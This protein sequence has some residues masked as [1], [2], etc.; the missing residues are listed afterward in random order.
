MD[1][2]HFFLVGLCM[3]SAQV[4]VSDFFSDAASFESF[5]TDP[6]Q[7]FV[8][9]GGTTLV[10]LGN[11]KSV[12]PLPTKLGY[13]KFLRWT[14]HVDPATHC[15]FFAHA[16]ENKVVW[17]LEPGQRVFAWPNI[18]GTLVGEELPLPPK[19]APPT[20]ASCG[21]RAGAKP[22][23]ELLRVRKGACGKSAFWGRHG[24]GGR[25]VCDFD[26]QG[27]QCYSFG[28]D[29]EFSFD[30]AAAQAG[31]DVHGFDPGG[32]PLCW[33]SVESSSSWT[34]LLSYH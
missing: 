18:D 17:E 12:I 9:G 22:P 29:D 32:L 24:D 19:S 8:V 4:S 20:G 14:R 16:T 23:F 7:H 34:V 21:K 3:S 33:P 26:A 10:K 15:L 2:W 31:C 5:M 13:H 27:E 1:W 28:I 11:G 25:D 30:S 6:A